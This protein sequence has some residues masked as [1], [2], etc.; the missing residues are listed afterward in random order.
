VLVLFDR[1]LLRVDEGGA[2]GGK[3]W[4]GGEGR[5]G[6]RG[7]GGK[8]LLGRLG[9]DLVC[10]SPVPISSLLVSSYELPDLFFE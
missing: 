6:G 9:D 3:G 2:V 1:Q 4:D 7:G 5:V 8:E 10:P